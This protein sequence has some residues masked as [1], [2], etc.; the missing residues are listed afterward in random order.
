MYLC[1]CCILF[2]RSLLNNI[3]LVHGILSNPLFLCW[4]VLCKLTRAKNW[5][6]WSQVCIYFEQREVLSRATCCCHP[7]I[8]PRNRASKIRQN[9]NDAIKQLIDAARFWSFCQLEAYFSNILITP[10][11]W[12]PFIKTHFSWYRLCVIIRHKW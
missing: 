10:P 6:V 12:I 4:S 3:A 2:L 11:K 7:T 9:L 5:Q 8:R 1:C